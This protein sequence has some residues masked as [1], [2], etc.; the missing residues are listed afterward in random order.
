[1]CRTLSVTILTGVVKSRY[2][3][4]TVTNF[5]HSAR[6]SSMQIQSSNGKRPI[7]VKE[8]DKSWQSIADMSTDVD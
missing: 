4:N 5:T 6:D 2:A 7:S 3:Q 1:M 8:S